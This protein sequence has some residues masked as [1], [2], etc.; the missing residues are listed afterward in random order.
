MGTVD[1][2]VVYS[3]F[4]I[5]YSP[6]L[7]LQRLPAACGH[8]N[9]GTVAL[10]LIS[11]AR[12]FARLWVDQLDV[13]NIDKR[14]FL[15]DAAA[16]VTLRVRPLMSLDHPGAFNFDLPGNGR[17]FEHATT[18]TFVAAGDNHYLIVLPDF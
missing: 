7:L 16:P 6:V 17:D 3:L 8:A 10:N 14:F 9:F 18:L 1:N 12:R 2:S 4:T 5:Y 11:D 13:R 15:D